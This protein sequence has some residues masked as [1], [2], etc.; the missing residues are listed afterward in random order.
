MSII[1]CGRIFRFLRSIF[2]PTATI[3]AFCLLLTWMFVLYQPTEG[4]GELQRLGWQAWES[5]SN[6]SIIPQPGTDTEESNSDGVDWWN[7]T[8][9][10]KPVDAASLPLDIWSPL[11]PHITGCEQL[12]TRSERY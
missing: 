11:L 12:A 3:L 10:T 9:E 2:V 4:P 7:V 5:V 6:Q 8:S 1:T